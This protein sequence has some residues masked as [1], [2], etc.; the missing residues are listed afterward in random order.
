MAEA[1]AP[2]VHPPSLPNTFESGGD[3]EYKDE[4]IIVKCNKLNSKLGVAV[5]ELQIQEPGVCSAP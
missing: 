3:L 1:S 2:I 5:F 4:R